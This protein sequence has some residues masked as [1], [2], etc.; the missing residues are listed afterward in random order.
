MVIALNNLDL[1]MAMA[2]WNHK[3]SM[4]ASE[5][6]APTAWANLRRTHACYDATTITKQRLLYL[7]GEEAQHRADLFCPRFGWETTDE[8]YQDRLAA[9]AYI[10]IMSKHID[11]F[12]SMLFDVP[13]TISEATNAENGKVAGIKLNT[14]ESEFYQDFMEGCDVSR[15][16]SFQHFLMQQFIS[17]ML[18]QV[19]YTGIDIPP[20]QRENYLSYGQQKEDGLLEPYLYHI[21]P[22]TVVDWQYS[23]D[24]D[25]QFNWIKLLYELPYQ[26]SPFDQPMKRYRIVLWTMDNGVAVCTTYLTKP[27][28]SVDE[29]DDKYVVPEET[30]PVV[31]TYPCIPIIPLC[32][33]SGL[34]IGA[35]LMPLAAEHFQRRTHTNYSAYRDAI[36]VPTHKQSNQIP[37]VGQSININA[38]DPNRAMMPRAKVDNN[39]IYQI[40]AEEDFTIVEAHGYVLEFLQHQNEDLEKQMATVVNQMATAQAQKQQQ[41]ATSAQS[42][43]EDRHEME[44][45]LEAFAEVVR[46]HVKHILDFLMNHRKEEIIWNIEGLRTKDYTDRMVL[47]QE[48]INLSKININSAT[49]QRAYK[50]KVGLAL[51]DDLS[52]LDKQQ[53]RDELAAD[54]YATPAINAPGGS[55]MAQ[56]MPNATGSPAANEVKGSE[57]P[58]QDMPGD[59]PLVNEQ[60]V[61]PG[62]EGMHL[63]EAESAPWSD[64]ND[65][66]KDDYDKKD[67]EPL[68][69]LSWKGPMS[70][71]ISSIDFSNVE[72]WRASQPGPDG[73]D[74]V[75]EFAQKMQ[76]QGQWKPVVL[77]NDPNNNKPMWVVD[78]RHRILAA[79]QT[80]GEVMAYVGAT[81]NIGPDHPAVKLHSKQLSYQSSTI[82][83]PAPGGQTKDGGT[84]SGVIRGNEA[85]KPLISRKPA[86]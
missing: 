1:Y 54:G 82:S 34:A 74:K 72:E 51:V 61:M 37:G 75:S 45:M 84:S 50:Y 6:L 33:H 44:V 27:V 46:D 81:S 14:L 24:N 63:A 79:K 78:G 66:L 76:D 77:V 55:D 42:K 62:F 12:S 38:F 52:D 11:F 23:E 58:L 13:L 4:E 5:N 21:D 85:T 9:G 48:A 29:L 71:P 31:T 39:G 70:V 25:H 86:Q 80:G 47:L 30:A 18:H 73:Q 68:S 40:G 20:Q 3:D 15:K 69:Y 8:H 36:I 26:P 7:G 57:N 64:V 35:K 43:Q 53:M 10:P 65:L 17:A 60:G 16:E 49:F 22:I 2:A 41:H 19:S 56:N 59:V 67:L 83:E 28:L 32:L